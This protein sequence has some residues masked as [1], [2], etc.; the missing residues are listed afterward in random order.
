MQATI[1]KRFF[2]AATGLAGLQPAGVAVWGNL[3]DLIYGYKYLPWKIRASIIVMYLIV[4]Y[5]GKE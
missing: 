4:L 3:F 2:I 5:R 1:A